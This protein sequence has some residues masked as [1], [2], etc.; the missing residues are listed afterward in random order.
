VY[1]FVA[2]VIYITV[3]A[4]VTKVSRVYMVA[5][6]TVVLL[7]PLL[8]YHCFSGYGF[9]SYEV[10]ASPFTLRSSKLNNA[11]PA[12]LPKLLF[13]SALCHITYMPCH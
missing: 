5:V 10:A 8:L 4:L 13:L 7:L 9:I 12:L 11:F 6:F 1:V 2:L 3:V